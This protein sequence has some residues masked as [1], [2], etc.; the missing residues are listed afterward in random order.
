[1]KNIKIR[2]FVITLRCGFIISKSYHR[3]P[4]QR[5]TYSGECISSADGPVSQF[6]PKNLDSFYHKYIENIF[7][8]LEIEKWD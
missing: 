6:P 8:R 5:K 3:P 7:C 1:V 2:I 4:W